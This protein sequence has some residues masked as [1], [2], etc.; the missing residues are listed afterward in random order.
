MRKD[1]LSRLSRAARWCL[2]PAEAAEVLED[3]R[4]LIEQEPRSEEELR[5]DLGSPW[6]A[7]RQLVQPK[8]YR[9]WVAVFAVLAVCILLP[10]VLP[11]LRELSEQAV[12]QFPAADWP[13]RIISLCDKIHPFLGAF[14]LTGMALALV[15]FRRRSGEERRQSLPKGVVPLLLLLLIG[16]AFEWVFIWITLAMI[17]ESLNALAMIWGWMT[18]D[19]AA[20][21]R[22]AMALDL[23]VMGVI[24][25][26]ALAKA[27]MTDRRWRAVYI[28]AL[29]GSI[30]GM[31]VFALWT[32]MDLSFSD[33]GWQ[34][35]ILVRYIAITVLGLV[36]T[37]VSLC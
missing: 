23:F 31:S 12:F 36:G 18:S 14:L 34:T 15:W 28:L 26:L 7:A 29:A 17:W 37:G 4:D 11:L 5:R 16:M 9:R 1:Y 6:S 35:P 24:G 20:A 27:R 3:Y 22:L 19:I 8:A 25:M 13:W 30:L 32:S 10:A 33:T 2:P 21:L